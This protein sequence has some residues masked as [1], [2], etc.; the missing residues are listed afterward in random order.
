MTTISFKD[1]LNESP[2]DNTFNKFFKEYDFEAVE[3]DEDKLDGNWHQINKKINYKGKLIGVDRSLL[4][5]TAVCHM[6][7]IKVASVIVP[8]I[9]VEFVS[10]GDKSIKT[11]YF[12][13]SKGRGW[14][15]AD[16]IK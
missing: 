3:I 13:H 10:R 6:K 2:I 15:N 11:Q 9:K 8:F 14:V 12:K 7:L 5:L 16:P 4:G 1:F